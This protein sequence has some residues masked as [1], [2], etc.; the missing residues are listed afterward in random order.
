MTTTIPSVRLFAEAEGP[1]RG[2]LF[3]AER[4][5]QHA[6]NLAAAQ[7]TTQDIGEGRPLLPRVLENGRILLEYY[8]ATAN[9]IQQGGSIAPAA[10]WLVDN[11]YIVEEQLREIRDDL[12]RGF[13]RRLPKLASGHLEGYPRVF[14]VAWAFVAHTD[15]RFEPE[16][17]RRFVNAYQKVQPLTIGEL[18]AL[19]ITLRVVLVENLRKLAD[20]IVRSR[21]AREEADLLVDSLLGIGDLPAVTPDVFRRFENEPLER[22]FAVQLVQRLRDMDP[23]VGPI[24][25]WLDKRLDAQGTT[26]D[27][28]VRA[29][30]QDQTAMTVTVRNVITSMRLMSAFDWHEFFETISTVDEVLRDGSRFEEMDF[31]ARDYYRKAIEELS[32]GSQ[33]A[34]IEIARRALQHAKHARAQH[35]SQVAEQILPADDPGYYLISKGRAGFERELGYRAP[36][37]QKFLRL[38]VRAAAWGYLG[39]ILVLTAAILT[40]PLVHSWDRGVAVTYLVLVGLIGAIPASDLAIAMVNRTVTALLGPRALPRLELLDGVPESLRTIVVMPTLLTGPDSIKEQVDRLEIHFL[41]NPDGDVR[42]ALLSDWTDAASETVAGDDDLLAAAAAGIDRLNQRHGPAPGGGDRFFLFHRKRVWNESQGKWMGWERKRGKLEELNRFLRGRTDTTFIPAAGRAPEPIPGVRYVLTLDA[43]TRVPRGTVARLVG[44][45][46]HPLNQPIYSAREGRVVQGYGIIQPRITATL[47][48]NRDGSLFQRIFSG[49]SGMDP[50][51]FAV[52][53]VYQDLFAEGTYTGKG[54]YDIDAFEEALTGKVNENTLLSHDLLEGIFA[55]AG[56]ASDIELFE[57]FPSHYAVSAARQHR[58]ARGDWQLLPWL[59]GKGG[60]SR[61]KGSHFTIPLISRWKMLDNLRRTLSAPALFLTFFLSWLIPGL[62]PLVWTG[63]ALAIISIPPLMP[64]LAGLRPIRKGTST[65]NHVRSVLGDLFLG[66]SQIGLTVTGLAYQAW[67]MADA[68]VRTLVRMFVTRKNLLEWVTAAQAKHAADLE[69]TGIFRQ[70]LGG[71]VLALLALG[72]VIEG[73]P[74]ALPVALPFLAL[75]V[76]APIFALRISLPPRLTDIEPL[77]PTEANELRLIARRTWHFFEIFVTAG[78]NWLPPDNF[79]E[80][81]KPIVAHRTSPTNIGLY[82]LSIV[83]ARDFG[84]LGTLDAVE[85][86]EG[87]VGTL[88]RMELF[89]GHLY[90][91]YSTSDLQPLEP[92]YISSVDSGNL[93]GNLIVLGNSCRGLIHSKVV[94]GR[95]LTALKDTI[96][97]LRESLAGGEAT[98][99]SHAVTQ[100]QLSNAVDELEVLLDASPGDAMEWASLLLELK[101]KAQTIDDIGLALAQ[102]Q[103]DPQNSELRVWSAAVRA[104]V[105]SH[106]RD[107]ELVNPWARLL[108]K[109]MSEVLA[110]FTGQLPEWKNLRAILLTMPT[111]ERAADHFKPAL[112]EM[113]AIRDRLLRDSSKNAELL[114]SVGWLNNAIARCLADSGSMVQRLV[115][116]AQTSDAMFFGMDFK[117]LFDQTKKL[118]SIGFRVADATLDL[119]CYDLLASEARLTSFIAIAKGDVPSSHWFRLGRFMTPVGRGSA[120][121]SWSG[122]MFEYLMP[123]LVMRSPEGSMLSQT[124]RQ[125]VLRQIE[126]GQERGAP[127]G[128]SESAFNARDLNLTYQYQ[129]FGIPGLGLKRGLSEDIVISPY[130]TALA[131]MVLPSAALANF[132]RIAKVGGEGRYGFYESLDYTKT[133]VPEGKDVAVIH[134]FMAHHQGM[135]LVSLANV[136]EDGVMRTRFHADPIVQATELL[137]QERTPRDTLVARPRAEEVSAVAKVRDFTPPVVRRFTSP[138]DPTPRTQLLSNGNYTVMM[139]AAGSGYS[140]WRDIAITRWR[141]DATRDCWGTYFFVQDEQS[142][143]IWSAGYQCTGVEPDHYEAEFYEDHVEFFRRDRSLNTKLEV[144][145]SSEEDAEVRRVSVTNLGA[146]TRDIQVTSYAE[147]ALIAQTADVAHPAFGNLFVETEFVPDLGALL[148]TRRKRSPE[149]PSVWV[150]HVLYVNGETVG[151]LEYE[152]DR[153]RFLGRGRNLR[154]PASIASGRKLSNTVGSVLDPSMS[155]RRTVRIEPGNTAHLVYTTIAAQTREQ[156]L[157]LADRYRDA[158]TFDRTLTLAWTHAQVQLHHLGI[159]PDESQLFQRLANAVIYPEAPLRPTSDQLARTNIDI[160]TLWS[161]GISGDLPIILAAID[162]EED[163]DVIRQL[164]RAHE[165]WRMKQLSADLVIVNEKP[166]SYNQDFQGSLEAL[167]HG[168][169][170]RLSPD[171]GNTRGRIFLVRGDLI[172]PQTRA[173]LQNVARVLIIGRR[174]TLSEQIGR[175]QSLSREPA[176]APARRRMRVPKSAEIPRPELDL[177][178]FNGIGGFDKN[179]REYV[180]VLG[181]GLRTPEPWVNV[182]ANPDFG[183]LISESGSGFT[184]SLNSHENQITPWSNDHLSDPSGEVIYVRDEVT[185]EIWCPTALPIRD[186]AA[187]YI[188]RHGQ[189]FSRFQHESHGIALDLLE[190]VPSGDPIKICRLSLKNTSGRSRRVSVTA[191]IEWVLGSSRTASAPYVVTEVDADT[192]ALFARNVMN[193][194]FGGRISFADLAGKQIAFTA[195]RAEFLGRNGTFQRPAGLDLGHPLSGKVGAGLDP[196]AALQAPLELRVG[197]SA[198]IVFFLGQTENK[199]KAR[200]LLRQYRGKDLDR[201][202]LDVTTGWDDVLD[203]VQ[204]STPDRATDLMLNRWLLYQTLCCRIWARA[205]FYQLSGAYGFRDQLQDVIALLTARREVAREQ[206][207]RAA[208]RQFTAGD[209]QHW[210]HPPSG[211]GVRT[212]ISDDRLWLPYTVVQFI[213]STGDTAVLDEIVPFLDGDLLAEGQSELYFQPNRSAETATMFEHCARALDCSLAVGSHGLPLMGTGDWNDGMNRVGQQGKGESVWLGFFLHTVLW[214]FSKIADVRGEF[215][216]AET[217]RLQVSALKAALEREGWD[218]AWYRRAFYDDGTPL[219]SAEN[220][221]CRIDSIAQSW[222]MFSGGAEIGRAARAM[223]A[224]N[225]QLVRPA[226]GLVLLLTPPFDHTPQDP[227][228]IKGYVPGIRENGGQYTHAA[229]WT[230]MAFAAL[231]DGDKAGELLRMLNPINRAGSRA[232]VQRYKVEPY[233]MAGDVY[234]EA[235]HVGRGGWTWYTGSAGWFYRAGLEWVL[236]FRVRGTTLSID[237]CIP[238]AWPS[239]SIVFRYHSAKYNVRVENPR[240]VTRGIVRVEFDGKTVPGPANIPLSDDG[241]EHHILVVL[242]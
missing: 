73:R 123:A 8:R 24:L 176:A 52:S 95:M 102:E 42:F 137:L 163:V 87:T 72:V 134:A 20:S 213:E 38:Y 185:G 239:Y 234:A 110:R 16:L 103:G 70:M 125:I 218:G 146:R 219:G 26:S 222:G 215:K 177:E 154:N 155:L 226:D 136:L 46:A 132:K 94:D 169:Q 209:V 65:R 147:L 100:K 133:R 227:G 140:R 13:Y 190:F 67:L 4:L 33:H 210:W 124:Y 118:F 34:E 41:A 80:D 180:T 199:E 139:T 188:A 55:R 45:M 144:V 198:E 173:Q 186:E 167:V 81:P 86:L 17:L 91:W 174:G 9:A 242:G 64:F 39:S 216:R 28:I 208:S 160:S 98:L 121:I 152:T 78:D 40:L 29:E 166:P 120:L 56:L 37:K 153:S 51:A 82:L 128:V 69:I 63:F 181:E 10:E 145:V 43:D 53:D 25:L 36:L 96:F 164:L 61:G 148:A 241:I 236:G 76:T 58:W 170:L 108:P 159:G 206:I 18:W 22:A 138:D 141:E 183:F 89:R 168:S 162:N 113:A 2:E 150:A 49:P 189:G 212:R 182:V 19:A 101:G 231:G 240:G 230:L 142:Q 114:A 30:H 207:L 204:V 237:P 31:S 200:E 228:Y 194:E 88:N 130:S 202:L 195:D 238:G 11:F 171:S 232:G 66:L 187:V 119:S 115:R 117:F 223:E 201:V 50:Y 191:Y 126:Y 54:I 178:Y 149:D 92:K 74:H 157:D 5:E 233:V 71:V 220:T 105:E 7:V 60:K 229:V 165:Y 221:E 93:A 6:E 158:R 127:W 77:S 99:R 32:R 47:P 175:S 106:A 197:G 143:N 196:C 107:M 116:L 14:G 90:N 57:E 205:G 85:H 27:E 75:W 203:A 1:I 3:S 214:E 68:I 109:Q 84:W 83:A 112:D 211:R 111:L 35:A 15:S 156:A 79:Q 97:F 172:S 224:V 62:S 44:T 217:W 122:S 225:R 161:L 104:C 179:G 129:G 12:P 131:A 151:D 23:K 235:P 192:G 48:A 184:W 135:S 193:S 21:K 59:I